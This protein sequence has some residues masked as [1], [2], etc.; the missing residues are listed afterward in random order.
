MENKIKNMQYLKNKQKNKKG[1]TLIEILLYSAILIIAGSL[2]SNFVYVSLKANQRVKVETELTNQMNRL[3]EIFRLKINGALKI[4]SLTADQLDLKMADTSVDPTV[5]YWSNDTLYLSEK[6]GSFLPLNDKNKIKVT[7]FS[8]TNVMPIEGG[9]LSSTYHYAWNDQVGWLDFAY[10]G[11][12]IFVPLSEGDLSGRVRILS[13]NS[14]IYLNCLNLGVCSNSNFKV[15]RLSNGDL[16]GWAWSENYGW[17]SFNCLNDNSCGA[18]S[19]KVFIDEDGVFHG[20][21][22]SENIGWI[23]FNCEDG[24][25]NGGNICST[26]DYKVQVSFSE[27]PILK[28]DLT[29][30]YNS[31][32]PDLAI[33]KSKSFIFQLLK[34][35]E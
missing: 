25:E 26:S 12:N 17:I 4:N 8:V 16:T 3:E 23:S 6:G 27:L 11:G 9:S 18:S 7:Q 10:S 31:P 30:T 34:P 24:G 14:W 5:F 32:K 29:L 33:S 13:D 35:E 28:I 22:W 1:F 2:I 20:W 21:A 15:E 19:Y